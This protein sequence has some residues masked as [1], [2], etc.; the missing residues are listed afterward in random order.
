[1]MDTWE[2]FFREKSRRRSVSSR[3]RAVAGWSLA[4]FACLLFVIAL[5]ALIGV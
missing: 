2:S 5:L 3:M 1:M 4:G